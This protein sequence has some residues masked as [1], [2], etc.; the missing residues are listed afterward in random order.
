MTNLVVPQQYHTKI[1]SRERKIAAGNR[2]HRL[3]RS[4]ALRRGRRGAP[5]LR[6]L[7]Y[8]GNETGMTIARSKITAQGQISVPAQVRRKLGL[9]PGSILEW[10]EENERIIVRRAGRYTSADIHRA[11]FPNGPPGRRTIEDMTAGI[12][13]YVKARHARR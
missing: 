10:H 9:R 1:I 12:R 13:R 8:R 4:P 2:L 6:P 3:P 7:H 11:L 5:A